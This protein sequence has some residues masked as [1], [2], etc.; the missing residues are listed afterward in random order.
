MFC[1]GFLATPYIL[2]ILLNEISK[3]SGSIWD[4]M[5]VK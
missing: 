5:P 1:S 3:T 4:G 2:Y